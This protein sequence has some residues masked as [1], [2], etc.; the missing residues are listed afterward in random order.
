MKIILGVT[1]SISIYK[2][3]EITSLL[4]KKGAEVKVIMTD[5]A[6]RMVS[7][8]PFFTL[9]SNIVLND[10]FGE[11]DYI[12]HISLSDWA[13][14]MLI[15]PATANIIGKF[16][17]GIADDL[18]STTFI[19]FNKK[20]LIAPA[21]NV[22]MYNHPI[23]QENIKK[24]Q[25]LDNI[26]FI[27]PVYG[28]LACGY[29]GKGKLA[30]PEY[31]VER[32]LSYN[33]P[34][35][36]KG[37]KVLV[38][39]GGTI[40]DIDPVRYITNRSSGLM[41]VSFAKKAKEM[42][43]DVTLIYG[44]INC[45]IPYDIEAIKIRSCNDMLDRLKNLISSYDVLIMAAAVA[46]FRVKSVS[47]KKIKKEKEETIKLELVMNPDILKELSTIKKEEQ[48][49]IGFSLETDDLIKN[50]ISKLERKKLDYIIANSPE[51]FES[52]KGLIKLIDKRGDILEIEGRKEDIAEKVLLK[53]FN[54][55]K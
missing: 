21:M 50:A 4:R 10:Q 45:S 6:M 32:V 1:S 48:I 20:V 37:K 7:K 26:E 43:A 51:N 22:K 9:S 44:N 18:L 28:N 31:I 17:N 25:K 11:K 42:G 14:I 5:N 24:L 47:D 41:G 8:I 36:L 53:I 55:K 16:A 29:E 35:I 34:K 13:D 54:S 12:P 33:M 40:E 46:D 2:A 15:A 27:E 30:P 38:T 49:F 23:V 3:L 52:E 19:S 39:T